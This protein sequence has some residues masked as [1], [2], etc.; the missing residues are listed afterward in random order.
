MTEEEK[1]TDEAIWVC[2][3]CGT[4]C[5]GNNMKNTHIKETGHTIYTPVPEDQNIVKK[6][7]KKHGME[8]V[9]IKEG[10]Y[11]DLKIPCPPCEVIMDFISKIIHNGRKKDLYSCNECGFQILVEVPFGESYEF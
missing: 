1:R 6:V 5:K 8:Q 9:S 2:D 11:A 10:P 7:F 4:H 3:I